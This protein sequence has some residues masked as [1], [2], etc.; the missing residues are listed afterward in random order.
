MVNANSAFAQVDPNVKQNTVRNAYHNPPADKG[1]HN[2]PDD[3]CLH[4]P[5]SDK[6]AR[7]GDTRAL[8]PAVKPADQANKLGTAKVDAAK[9]QSK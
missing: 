9:C 7:S 2:P 3:K 1:A 8:L 4:N 5:P 6:S